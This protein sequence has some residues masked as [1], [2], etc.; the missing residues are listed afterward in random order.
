MRMKLAAVLVFV[1]A[2][3]GCWFYFQSRVVDVWLYTDYAFRSKHADWP[4]LVRSRFKEV[5]R[6]YQRNGTGILWKVLDSSQTDPTSELPG[7]DS[8]R[9]NMALHMDRK[10]DIFVILTGIPEGNRTGSVSPFT[11]VAVVVDFPEKSEALNGRLMADELARLFGASYDP[12][13]LQSLQGEKPESD[14]FS[15]RNI[16][17]IKRM[18]NYPFALGIDGL[19][20]SWEKKAVAALAEDGNPSP[21]PAHFNAMARA[22]TVIGMA[23]LSERK[24]DAALVH[25]RLAM[26]ADPNSTTARLNL[27]EVYS[28][29][30]RDDLALEQGREVV[31]LA[32]NDPLS[33]RELGALLGRAHQSEEA[34]REL[35]IAARMEPNN[36]EDRILL[37]MQFAGMFGR[38][39]DA[40][41]TLQEA[42]R[43]HPESPQALQGLEQMQALKQ[44]IAED[45]VTQRGLLQH[46]PNDADAN[47]RLA[48]A[49]ARAGDVAGAIRDFRK[50]AD[51]R[52]ASGTTHVELAELYYIQGDVGGAWA[53][54]RKARALGTEPPRTLIA[55]LPAQ[56]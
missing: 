32:P 22:H 41:A 18:R 55:R 6:I 25:Y 21:T 12:A 51:L 45:L 8:R 9:A 1:A 17:L 30:G 13:G 53:E 29:N 42:V 2:V 4:A 19:S 54:V 56:K 23:L 43:L 26:Q 20:G 47:Y 15:A 49:E 10:T 24:K 39:D 16:A 11:R 7:I 48:K 44:R 34:V 14:R 31:R 52:P 36:A 3:A 28:R 46:N 5:N 50:S 35:Q 40:I 27:A 37:A 33:H 38:L